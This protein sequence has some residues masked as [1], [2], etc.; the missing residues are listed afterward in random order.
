MVAV[1]HW[2]NY[3]AILMFVVGVQERE[4]A[5]KFDL[6]CVILLLTYTCPEI[7]G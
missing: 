1:L 5:R 3:E 2:P 6:L 7:Q 4:S